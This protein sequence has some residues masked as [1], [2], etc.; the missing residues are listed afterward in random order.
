MDELNEA[1]RAELEALKQSE[2]SQPNDHFGTPSQLLRALR[3]RKA[4]REA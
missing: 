3:A 4:A 1:E 2:Q